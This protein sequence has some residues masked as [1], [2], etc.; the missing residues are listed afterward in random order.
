[1][2]PIIKDPTILT[3]NVPKG[4]FGKMYFKEL[5]AKNLIVA[6]TAPP[7]ANQKILIKLCY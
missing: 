2:K 6:P 1:M 3:N 5:V 7:A 4:K